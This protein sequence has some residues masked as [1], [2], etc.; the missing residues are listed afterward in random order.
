MVLILNPFIYGGGQEHGMRSG[1]ENVASII[2][3]GKAC[4]LAKENIQENISLHEKSSNKTN[5]KGS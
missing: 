3:F 4:Q 2:G 5:H 1:T